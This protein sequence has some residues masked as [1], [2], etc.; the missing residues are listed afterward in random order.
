MNWQWLTQTP[1]KTFPSSL[2]QQF[3]S[4]TRFQYW[5]KSTKAKKFFVRT[6]D[7]RKDSRPPRVLFQP[8]NYKKKP[9]SKKRESCCTQRSARCVL[10][11]KAFPICVFHNLLPKVQYLT[12]R[13]RKSLKWILKVNRLIKAQQKAEKIEHS[14][15]LT[16]GKIQISLRNTTRWQ[17]AFQ[18]QLAPSNPNATGRF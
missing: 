13:E 17:A 5:T 12:A 6:K 7:L 14:S 16:T 15:H 10:E 8:L 9:K 11:R 18:R 1:P 2:I 3:G 4:F